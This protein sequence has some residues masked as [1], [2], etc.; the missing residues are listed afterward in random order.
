MAACPLKL[1]HRF[2]PTRGP[3]RRRSTRSRRTRR[4][5][6]VHLPLAVSAVFCAEKT[7]T[8]TPHPRAQERPP[9][10][11]RGAPQAPTPP[12]PLLPSSR[13]PPHPPGHHLSPPPPP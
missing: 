3:T 4:Q 9:H 11:F 12:P 10:L 6:P 13:T 1:K 8:H 5:G 7:T 2:R